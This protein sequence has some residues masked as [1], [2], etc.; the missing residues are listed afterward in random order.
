MSDMNNIIDE[1]L[2]IWLQDVVDAM[3]NDANRQMRSGFDGS[4]LVGN[5]NWKE[6]RQGEGE[7]Y[8]PDYWPFFEYGVAAVG[9]SGKYSFKTKKVSRSHAMAVKSWLLHHLGISTEKKQYKG[10]DWGIATNVKKRGLPARQFFANNF[11]PEAMDIL[12]ERIRQ[13]F[14]TAIFEKI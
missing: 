9:Q 14:E 7:I 4:K 11:N 6:S 13:R 2:A 8:M 3:I 1:E 12:G 10:M 5:I